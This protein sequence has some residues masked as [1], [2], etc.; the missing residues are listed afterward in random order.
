[1]TVWVK[2]I[3]IYC[4]QLEAYNKF[5]TRED[6]QSSLVKE[7]INS[8]FTKLIKALTVLIAM[9]LVIL[10]PSENLIFKWRNISG[11]TSTFSLLF[12][13][14]IYKYS[15]VKLVSDDDDWGMATNTGKCWVGGLA[16]LFERAE[17]RVKYR[18]FPRS[19]LMA[20]CRCW[21]H[22]IRQFLAASLS[23]MISCCVRVLWRERE[24]EWA[25]ETV[26][27]DSQTTR[28]FGNFN[29]IP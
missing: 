22:R 23:R 24:R 16:E 5:S 13:Y 19:A 17:V 21:L 14:S 6:D 3:L 12:I 10:P 2:S 27:C 28:S 26:I 20:S 18:W 29:I 9:E 4:I 8:W 7:K 1:M 25:N 11:Y 15:N